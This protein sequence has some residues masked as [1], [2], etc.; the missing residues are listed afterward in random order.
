MTAAVLE[1]AVAAKDYGRLVPVQKVRS[2]GRRMTYWTLPE[3][4][5]QRPMF[6]PETEGKESATG[7]R[8][9]HDHV[10]QQTEDYKVKPLLKELSALSPE[11]EKRFRYKYDNYAF[12]SDTK[13]L[14]IKADTNI[15]HYMKMIKRYPSEKKEWL[16]EYHQKTNHLVAQACNRKRSMLRVKMGT[17]VIFRGVEGRVSGFTDKGFPVVKTA[18]GTYNAFW[19]EVAQSVLDRWPR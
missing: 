5:K 15:V 16:D 14:D 10:E 3:D 17:Q 11:L 7:D 8:G 13:D 6:G 12:D 18:Q 19:E 2:D 4:E 9:Y 1:K